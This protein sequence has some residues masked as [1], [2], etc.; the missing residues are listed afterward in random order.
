[1]NNSIILLLIVCSNMMMIIIIIVYCMLQLSF[2]TTV[3]WTRMWFDKQC[4]ASW[5]I[6]HT[7]SDNCSS[8]SFC[9]SWNG[10]CCFSESRVSLWTLSA[11][12]NLKIML[13]FC[14]RFVNLVK[15]LFALITPSTVLL[16]PGIN[17]S[18]STKFNMLITVLI[19]W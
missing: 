14:M 15:G 1:M 5:Q 19:C 18:Y 7:G 10:R 13:C 4:E 12:Y 17:E 3:Y 11:V 16:F 6:F 8:R 9:Y 2:T